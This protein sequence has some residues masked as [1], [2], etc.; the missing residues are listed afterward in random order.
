[1]SI[2]VAHRISAVETY[3]FAKKLAE[4]REMNASGM[5]I[6]NLG[7]GSPDLPPPPE[8]I[9]TLQESSSQSDAHGYQSYYGHPLLKQ[10]FKK[11][12]QKYFDIRLDA[13]QNILPLIGSKEGIMHISMAFLQAGDQVLIPNPGY[14]A[15]AATA[16]IAG[17]EIIPY[18]LSADNDWHP[19][20]KEIEQLGDLS[21]VKI[22][23]VN[24]PH[25]PTGAKGSKDLFQSL[26]DFGKRHD[27]LI[28]HDNP[29]AFILNDE[30]HSIHQIKG[31]LDCAIEL[32]SL[33]KCYNMAGWRI[34][35]LAASSKIIAE[36]IKFKSNMDSGMFKPMQIAAAKALE[37][38]GEW[39]GSLNEIYRKRKQIAI[40]IFD[41]LGVDY[42]LNSAGLF[43]WGKLPIGL[44]SFVESDR[45]LEKAKVFITPGSIFGSNGD[46]YLRISLCTVDERLEEAFERIKTT[47]A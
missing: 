14:P 13:E 6:I 35:A 24:Y 16:K 11:W 2:Q 30:V 3:F 32:V 28:C 43:V 1:M 22:M 26:V 25:M 15:Y 7:I 19:D 37:L 44:N 18:Y 34:G 8:V 9:A 33:S 46:G 10:A 42:Q 4:I 38:G 40:K 23:W 5:D 27:I 20:F 12:Y 47:V 21:K 36:V 17:A 29:Y 41:H 31:S 39:F 45:I